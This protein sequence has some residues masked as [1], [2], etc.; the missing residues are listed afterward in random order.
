[1]SVICCR[2]FDIVFVC[3][4]SHCLCVVCVACF[5]GVFCCAYVFVVR[6]V[7]CVLRVCYRM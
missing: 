7:L 5:E 1:M 2:L 3:L 6:C 4:V